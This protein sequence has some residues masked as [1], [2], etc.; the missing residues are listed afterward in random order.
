MREIEA[1][2]FDA[3]GT[4]FEV[5]GS[6]GRIYS[7]IA[8]RY[9]VQTHPE[10]LDRAFSVALGKKSAQGIAPADVQDNVA[11]EKR[12]WSEI[13][14]SV[15]ADNMPKEAFS[16]YFDEVFE[17]F[18][19]ADAWQLYPETLQCLERLQA[20]GCGLGIISN[21]DSRLID[22]LVNLGIGR[23]FADVTLSWTAGAAKPDPRIFLKAT[24]SMGIPASKALHVGDSLEEDFQGARRA[25]LHAVLLDRKD[26]YNQ[27][28]DVLRVRSLSELTRL[29]DQPES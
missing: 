14:E 27:S 20:R 1:V 10:A 12:W 13:V 5:R 7:A 26:R 9:G 23:F 15:L 2:F 25:G 11:E 18:R 22:L 8:L 24:E 17:F 28:T 29:L 21:F 19:S 3:A 4:L 6:V 16:E